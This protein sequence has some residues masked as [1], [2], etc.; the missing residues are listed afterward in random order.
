VYALPVGH[1]KKY[2]SNSNRI[3]DETVGGWR[4]AAAGLSYSGFPQSMTAGVSSNTNSFGVE[5]ANQYRP[6]HIRHRSLSNWFGDDPS[7]Q[8]CTTSGVDNGVCAFGAAA[9]NTFGSSSNGSVRGP[10]FHNV[11]MSMMKD[12]RIIHEH[13]IGFRFDAFNAFNIVSYGNPDTGINDTG[14]GEIVQQNAIRSAERHLQFSL[15]YS[16]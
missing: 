11:D 9:Q 2:L 6:L 14:F 3:V 5:R 12:F 10:G 13:F 16:F 1:G 4:I 8:P 7:A 15:R